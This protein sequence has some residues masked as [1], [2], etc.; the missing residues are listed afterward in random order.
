MNTPLY[1]WFTVM[2][3]K[4]KPMTGPMIIQ[5]AESFYDEMNITGKCTFSQRW[6][7]N[8]KNQPLPEISKLITTAISWAAQVQEQQ[9][10]ITCRKLGQYR[11]RMIIRHPSGPTGARLNMIIRHP[12]GPTG[13]RL[14]E[15]YCTKIKNYVWESLLSLCSE[16]LIF[17]YHSLTELPKSYL[18]P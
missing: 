4:G 17:P 15:F 13:A 11:Y 12:S 9:Q 5:K 16:P 10:K 7:Q 6:L 2:C 1:K 18:N 8:L 3:P 14:T